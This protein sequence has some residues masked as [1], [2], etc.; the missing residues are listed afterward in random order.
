MHLIVI[1]IYNRLF[2]KGNERMLIYKNK[3]SKNGFI[4]NRNE[5]QANLVEGSVPYITFPALEEIKE[6]G[7]GFSTKLGGVS[8]GYLS[9]MNLS[10]VRG[11]NPEFVTENYKRIANTLGFDTTDLVM[12]DQVHDIKIKKVTEEEKQG[13][14]LSQKK[15]VGIDGLITNVPN[16]VLSTSYADCV[17]I[18][19]VDMEKKA[20]GLSHSGWKGTVGQIGSRTVEAM[21]QEFSSSPEDI[22]AVIGP[23]ICRDCYEVSKEVT[24]AFTDILTNEQK[25]LI[26]EEKQNEKY[27]LDLWL[28]NRFILENAGLLSD[29]IYISEVCTCCNGDLLYS[30]RATNGLRG[31]LSAFLW[32]KA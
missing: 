29:N 11:D 13:E 25:E 4:Y 9:S 14:N 5:K 28:A 3:N 30:H 17:P 16:V 31:N 22:I 24:D 23:S 10:Y 7:H 6:I 19:L 18:F 20:I 27:Q 1:T 15:L 2:H 32:L 21:R 8:Q 12:S 26:L